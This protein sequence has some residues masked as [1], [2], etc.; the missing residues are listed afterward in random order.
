MR[1]NGESEQTRPSIVGHNCGMGQE[2]TISHH[3]SHRRA[4]N[5]S[6]GRVFRSAVVRFN[7]GLM[8][9]GVGGAATHPG[10]Q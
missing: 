5:S 10:G 6:P 1:A 9:P 8:F 4:G 3:S 7:L 2:I